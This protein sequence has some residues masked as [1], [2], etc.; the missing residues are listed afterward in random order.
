MKYESKRLFVFPGTKDDPSSGD[1]S[2]MLL[3][4]AIQ[5]PMI[6]VINVYI[7][8]LWL[9]LFAG[10]LIFMSVWL[11]NGIR[12]FVKGYSMINSDRICSRK[13][14]D[15]PVFAWSWGGP[16]VFSIMYFLSSIIGLLLS[17]LLLA[18]NVLV[19]RPW[20]ES[21]VIREII[22]IVVVFLLIVFI[23]WLL[24]KRHRNIEKLQTQSAIEG[25]DE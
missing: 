13:H 11:A 5:T 25:T 15:D 20:I 8:R 10:W 18:I 2:V 9:P 17:L 21:F 7:D 19:L 22:S 6:H 3:L 12:E 24:V 1:M 23:I 4:L 14:N 16:L